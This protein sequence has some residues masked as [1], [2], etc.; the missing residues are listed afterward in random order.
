MNLYSSFTK[1]TSKKNHSIFEKKEN[2]LRQQSHLLKHKDFQG[3]GNLSLLVQKMKKFKQNIFK[4]N[5][6]NSIIEL[7]VADIM[8][9]K[10]KIKKLKLMNITAIICSLPLQKIPAKKNHGIFEKK[11]NNLANVSTPFYI[12]LKCKGS[13]YRMQ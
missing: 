6:L 9:I 3:L 12:L 5:G 1:N 4:I 7:I 8:K 13:S 11:D 2:R 10:F